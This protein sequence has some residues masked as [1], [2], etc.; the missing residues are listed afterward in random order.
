[1]VIRGQD[2]RDGQ[3]G[4]EGQERLEAAAL[5]WPIGLLFIF[6]IVVRALGERTPPAEAT[7]DCSHVAGFDVPAFERCLDVRPDD[8]GLM[9][10]LG[11]EHERAGQWDRAESVYR[12]AL[13]I[14][15]ED[16]DIR[17]RLGNILLRRG[18]AA[19]ARREAVA[20]LAVQ[21]GRAPALALMSR[22]EAA[23]SAGRDR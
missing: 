22:A 20:A 10:D 15:A 1:V 17:V 5:A 6:F 12:R 13:A 8:V 9:T 11:A 7:I 2:G 19:G 18:D 23:E 4:P 14:D 3:E 21:P 16:G